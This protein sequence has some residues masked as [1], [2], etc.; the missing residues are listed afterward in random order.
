VFGHAIDATQITAI[1]QRNAQII[2]APSEVV[3]G[4]LVAGIAWP[5]RGEWVD[6]GYRLQ[7]VFFVL[8]RT[9][10]SPYITIC[11]WQHAA[12]LHVGGSL[13]L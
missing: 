6:E 8:H 3:V 1:G 12:L 4:W 2:D 9:L 11:A 7:A 13:F 10:S 5:R